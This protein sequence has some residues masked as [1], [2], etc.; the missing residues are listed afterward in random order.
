LANNPRILIGRERIQN[1]ENVISEVNSKIPDFK[2]LKG[3][4]KFTIHGSSDSSL[5]EG[6]ILKAGRAAP[7]EKRSSRER[8]SRSS[9]HF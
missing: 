2:F 9:I 4:S 5:K 7:K 6:V 1:V 3:K 8:S